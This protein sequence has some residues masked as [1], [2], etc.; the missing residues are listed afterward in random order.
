MPRI[1][2]PGQTLTRALPLFRSARK[3]GGLIELEAVTGCSAGPTYHWRADTLDPLIPDQTELTKPTYGWVDRIASNEAFNNTAGFGPIYMQASGSGGSSPFDAPCI[4]FNG[5]NTS[6]FTNAR[7]FATLD[8]NIALT[9]P[10]YSCLVIGRVVQA[11]SL[12]GDANLTINTSHMVFQDPT[13]EVIGLSG[14]SASITYNNV[15]NGDAPPLN[16][17]LAVAVGGENG[18]GNGSAYQNNRL[19]ANAEGTFNQTLTLTRLG[20]DRVSYGS[21]PFAEWYCLDIAVYETTAL[22]RACMAA[23]YEEYVKP[24]YPFVTDI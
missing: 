7:Q 23:I 22:T 4:Y 2:L 16:S 13:Q 9:N 18:G 20:R 11:G 19:T 12:L 10:N 3:R 17:Y 14:S 6:T 5:P 1:V 8:T 24:R 21:V 15:S